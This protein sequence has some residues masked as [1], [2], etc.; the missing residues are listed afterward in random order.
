MKLFSALE[1]SDIIGNEY[2][3]EIWDDGFVYNKPEI[4]R[5]SNLHRAR[6]TIN[7]NNYLKN[8]ASFL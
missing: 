3:L 2:I 4:L 5:T 6:A 8:D 1:I 7:Q